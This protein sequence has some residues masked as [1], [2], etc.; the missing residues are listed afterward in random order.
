MADKMV[1]QLSALMDSECALPEVEMAMRRLTKD[2]DL[3]ARWQRYHLISDT[4]KNNIPDIIDLDLVERI[5]Q[6]ISAD[7]PLHTYGLAKQSTWNKPVTGFALA[8]SV[9]LV[10]FAG[11]QLAPFEV[12]SEPS[13][14]AATAPISPAP[15]PD[16]SQSGIANT[17]TSLEEKLNTYL[18][19]HNEHA[20]MHSVHGVLPYV[21]MV[22]YQA[23]R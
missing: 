13:L 12:T 15:S 19:S 21:R 16:P 18:V 17:N 11:F 3:Q 6:A 22:G 14:V 8:A 9:A 4:L 10:A 2:A 23:N 5:N 7:P 1:E 20:S